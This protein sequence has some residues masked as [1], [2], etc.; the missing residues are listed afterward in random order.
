MRFDGVGLTRFWLGALNLFGWVALFGRVD[1]TLFG[2]VDLTRWGGAVA[3][4]RVPAWA[5][6]SADMQGSV[7]IKGPGPNGKCAQA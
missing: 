5:R 4:E 7:T 1:L 6:R 3:V 2:R